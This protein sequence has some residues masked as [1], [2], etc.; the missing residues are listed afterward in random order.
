MDKQASPAIDPATTNQ[1][2]R[3][4]P[5]RLSRL[6]MKELREVLRDRRTITTLLL[7]PLLVYPL[8]GI[9]VQKFLLGSLRQVATLSLDIGIANEADGAVLLDLLQ[10]GKAVIDRQ[11][12][13]DD[14]SVEN[15]DSTQDKIAQLMGVGPDQPIELRV[16]HPFE[17]MGTREQLED[18]VAQRYLH[19]GA[20]LNHISS[21]DGHLQQT[22]LE[23]LY[24]KQSSASRMARDE[25]VS[26]I[27][28][29]N[30]SWATDVLQAAGIAEGLPVSFAEQHIPSREQ[31]FSVVTIIPLM[32]VLMTI[33]GAVY[34]AIDVTAG[35]RERGTLEIL[36]AAPVSRLSLLIGKFVAVL[37]V[38]ML[39]A[40]VNL[41]AML[42][43]IYA[44]GV[45]EL[46]F[47]GSGLSFV[48]IAQVLLLLFV[49]AAFFSAL[50]LG[51]TSFARSFK[52]AQ[53]YLIP[54]MLVAL[55]PGL[56]SLMPD[57]EL[58]A[59]L[60]IVP[61]INIVLSGRDLLQGS[62]NPSLFAITLIS[63]VL[64]GALS[65]SVAARVFGADS[66]LYG[67]SGSW[68]DLF[69]RP[70]VPTNTVSIPAALLCLA[71]L[72]PSFIVVGGLSSQ[73]EISMAD[74]LLA[75][76]CVTIL[77]FV[78]IPVLFCLMAHARLKSVFFLHSSS[79]WGYVSAMLLGCSMWMLA[80]ELEIFTLSDQRI[81][82]LKEVFAAMRFDLG[83]I[84]L[85]VK[86]LALSIVPA[87]CEE[88]F[89]RGYLLNAFLHRNKPAIAIL[90]V[91]ALFGL[92]HVVVRDALMFERFLPSTLMG[93]ALGWIC[94]RTGSLLPGVLMHAMHNGLL[95][96]LSHF[97]K[98]LVKLGI[99]LESRSHLPLQWFVPAIILIV[100]GIA[101][102]MHRSVG[103][104]DRKPT[105]NLGIE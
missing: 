9:T 30:E 47:G 27:H 85:P 32:L 11:T 90:F 3:R 96:T 53:A 95:V 38:A 103:N 28:A 37:T 35:E 10:R 65:M 86:L 70:E 41:I 57:L 8:V 64:Y 36:I 60:A 51:L 59:A 77:L 34:P 105:A 6:A 75:N 84:S 15:R 101:L 93:V 68:A 87:V 62:L 42:M 97:E 54:L 79:L 49:F 18:L 69:R 88:F 50:M 24:D 61:L 56:L 19:V 52:E 31:S 43:T 26:R 29:I 21:D 94:Y 78:G 58:N 48:V 63:T 45:N 89:F 71:V 23:L 81:E 12:L 7:M 25:V 80:Y 40:A 46:L 13:T 2:R 16:M 91:A 100:V 73:L 102:T 104:E 67:S 83:N 74:K 20:L 92:F 39:T 44:L 55:A 98:D 82:F 72:F 14:K 66:I 76:A 5:I 1:V 33:T 22:T 99:G 17:K 4:S